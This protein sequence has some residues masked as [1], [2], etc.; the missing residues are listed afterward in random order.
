MSRVHGGFFRITL[1]L[2]A[3]AL[4]WKELSEHS[5]PVFPLRAA[6]FLWYLAFGALLLLSLLYL[7]KCFC[8]FRMVKE[9][10]CHP[11][12]VNYSFAPWISWLLLLQSAPR[13]LVSPGAA[14]YPVLFWAFAVPLILLDVKVYGQWLTTEKRFLSTTAN[15][16]SQV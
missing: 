16:T 9:E 4:L 12:G 3:Q 13:E 1:S 11:V 5:R 8:H 2:A 14:P 7:L 6:R 15:P 10:F